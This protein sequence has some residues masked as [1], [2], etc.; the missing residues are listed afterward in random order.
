MPRWRLARRGRAMSTAWPVSG[1]EPSP[2]NPPPRM[3]SRTKR[4]P[5]RVWLVAG[6]V[7]VD[8]FVV[9]WI[10]ASGSSPQRR[11]IHRALP[12]PIAQGPRLFAASSI[13]NTALPANAPVD[14]GS[15]A[16]IRQFDSQVADE[17]RARVGPW[18]AT[19]EASEPIYLVGPSQPDV[20]VHLDDPGLAW[21]RSLQ[22]AFTAVPVPSDA[23]AGPG[24][25]EEMTVW[26]PSTNKLWEFFHMREVD[27]TWHAAWGGAMDDVS[28][29]PGY[30]TAKSWP[31]A[32]P[33]WGAT[34]TSLPVAAGVITLRD[35][36]RGV[37]DH[38]L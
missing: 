13:W 9:A 25:D 17:I 35:F 8:A 1:M 30:Y 27:G 21:R 7:V 3:L 19:S 6:L 23:R 38:A 22:R 14:P 37:I 28:G 34:A 36:H 29:S 5:T 33:Q 2:R 11:T 18:L 12:P 31:G 26:Q 16:L 32:V 24:S 20:E 4:T 15:A 10:L